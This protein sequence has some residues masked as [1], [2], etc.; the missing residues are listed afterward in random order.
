M[1]IAYPEKT[2]E[3]AL[4]EAG[5]ENLETR[6]ENMCAKFFQDIQQIS[7]PMYKYLPPERTQR[8]LRYQRKYETPRLKTNR[9]KKITSFLWTFSI[10][11]DCDMHDFQHCDTYVLAHF[12]FKFPFH[13]Y[14]YRF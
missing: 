1:C 14:R 8:N 6:R 13:V 3:D 7:H 9:L 11:V 12:V 4:S 10:S 5:I 2:Y